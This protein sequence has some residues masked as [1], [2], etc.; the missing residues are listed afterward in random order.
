MEKGKHNP[1]LERP[2]LTGK[3]TETS[4]QTDSYIVLFIEKLNHLDMY[5]L[6]KQRIWEM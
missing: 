5:L 2:K 4:D 6:Q 1:Y 3:C